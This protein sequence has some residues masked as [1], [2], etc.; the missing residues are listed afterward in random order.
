MHNC[1]NYIIIVLTLGGYMKNLDY[2]YLC[3]II[4]NLAGIPV[5]T[6]KYDKQVFYHSLVGL[7]KDP[8]TPYL[9]DILSITDHVGYYIT[10]YFNY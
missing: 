10:P 3:A 9:S 8:I 7:P 5:R 2:N 4:G 6:Y 1:S